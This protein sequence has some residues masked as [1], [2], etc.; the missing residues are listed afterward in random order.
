MA[1]IRAILYYLIIGVCIGLVGIPYML[2]KGLLQGHWQ[3]STRVCI[4]FFN[5]IFKL[6][7]IKLTIEGAHN[8]PQSKNFVIV[9]NHQSFLDINVIWPSIAI[10]AFIA[11]AT[12]WKFPFF[13]W[14]L[15]HI[16]CIPVHS[17]PRKNLGMGQLVKERLNNGY[18]ITVFPEGHRSENGRML[19][20]Q[21]GIF[22]MAKEEKFALLPVTLVNT[23]ERLSKTKWSFTPGEVKIVVHP[24]QT[25][26]SFA[27]KSAVQLKNCVYNLI[28]Q[29][30][31]YANTAQ[32]ATPNKEA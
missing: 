19:A 14:V 9:A 25:P 12:L 1:F 5:V 28:E 29:A 16:G 6:F 24:L 8:I 21:N 11:K 17:N 10:T 23:G 20:F 3:E 4:P 31:P 2:F 22:R 26:E 32:S 30:L 7:S 13:G 18:T 27:E 15:T